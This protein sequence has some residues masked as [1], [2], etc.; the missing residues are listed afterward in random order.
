MADETPAAGRL[1]STEPVDVDEIGRWDL[2]A[3]VVV[4]G[5]GASGACAAL[6][7]TEIGADV[8]VLEA[9][10]GA[11]GTSAMSGGLIYLGGGTPIQQACGFEDTA[12]DMFAFLMAA[13]GPG[14]DE[15]KVRL[16]CDESVDH[17]HW[18]VG[19]GVPFKAGFYPEPG[20]EP[21]TD[22][23]LVYSGG[24]D[25]HPFDQ[26]AR[27]A[28]RGHKPQKRHA[29]GGFLMERLAEAV[30]ATDA[31]VAPDARVQR[32]VLDGAR[33]VG[34][35]ARQGGHDVAVRARCGVVLCAGGFVHSDEMVARHTPLVATC[36][37]RLG[38]DFDDGT[39]IRMA[40][41]IGA[42]VMRMDAAECAV[43]MTP[44]RSLVAGILVNGQGQRF[45]NE[46]TYYGRVGQ[47]VLLRQEGEAYLIVDEALY[48]VTRAGLQAS[49][50]CE[51]VEEL[52]AEIGL[53][54]GS[55][56]STFDLY[57]RHAA[58]GADPLFKK[59][60]EFVRPLVPPLGAYDLRVANPAAFYATFTLG[61]LSTTVDGEV[62]TVDG[63]PIPG[64]FAAGR[65]TSGIAAGGYV[66]GIS[67]GDGTFFGRRAGRAAAGGSS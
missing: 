56:V 49:W 15:A 3:D 18:L 13:C 46:D 44:P 21:P 26:I 25:A 58:D 66:S 5:L 35:V 12:E 24:E 29:A 2:E 36:S 60:G 61:G 9:S 51:T 33:V 48:E 20:L 1:L 34:L 4:V 23:A 63:A 39:G 22:D 14:A 65:T 7:A 43:P 62:L 40:Q 16:Y 59:S 53:P 54:A 8:L 30:A 52:E 47:E 6:G 11:G 28:P 27:P 55:L 57:Q 17:Y 64:L 50:V 19:R 32:L 10:G 67:L 45:I 38:N 31:R 41:S 37:L 42:A